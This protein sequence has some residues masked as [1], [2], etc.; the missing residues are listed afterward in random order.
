LPPRV[1]EGVKA[2]LL[3]LVD[4]AVERGWSAR[5]AAGLVS[6]ASLSGAA[7]RGSSSTVGSSPGASLTRGYTWCA[8]ADTCSCS[9]ARPRQPTWL[10]S[11]STA[12]ED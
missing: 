1:A 11:F 2:G 3:D 12:D 5:R 4:Y 10:P 6:A 9:N 8:A 7:S